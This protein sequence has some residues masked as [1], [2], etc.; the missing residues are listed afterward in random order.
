MQT[1]YQLLKQRFNSFEELEKKISELPDSYDRGYAFEDFAQSFFVLQKARYQ[2]KDF[3]L[4]KDIPVKIAELL[5]LEEKD[6]GVDGIIVRID[7]AIIAVQIKFRSQNIPLTYT[8]LSTFWTEA[9]HADGCLTFTNSLN[10]PK[11]A[12][13]RRIP[14]QSITL[15]ELLDLDTAFFDQMNDYFNGNTISKRKSYNREDHQIKIIEET[16]EKIKTYDRG[17]IIAACGTGKTVISKWLHDDLNSKAT[18]FFAPSLALIKQTIDSWTTNTD[19]PFMYMAVCSDQTV[20]N[21]DENDAIDYRAH[22]MSF[23]VSTSPDDIANFL[24]SNTDFPKVIFCTYQSADAIANALQT[25]ET[26]SK[27]K[28]SLGLY[29]EAHRTAG[30]KNSSMFTVALEDESIPV[31]KRIFLTATE[32]VASPRLKRAYEEVGETIYSMD[33]IEQYGHT[34]STYN[35]GQAIKDKII[36]NYQMVVCSISEDDIADL[37]KSYRNTV[38]IDTS[39]EEH[40][41]TVE[42]LLLQVILAKAFDEL[43]IHKTVAYLNRVS[44]AKRFINNPTNDILLSD[45]FSQVATNIPE[46]DLYTNAVDGSMSAK[47]RKKILD[48]FANAPFGVIANAK[49]LTEG[50]DVPAIDAVFFA[51]PKTSTVDIIQAIGRA[52]R[53]PKTEDKTAYIILPVIVPPGVQTFDGINAEAFET[54][55]NVI[56]ALADQDSDLKDIIEQINYSNGR[57]GNFGSNQKPNLPIQYLPIGKLN[58]PN[59][60]E[61][62]QFRIGDVNSRTTEDKILLKALT[63]GSRGSNI[64]RSFTSISDYKEEAMFT[65]LIKP[66]LQIFKDRNVTI[67]SSNEIKINNNNVSHTYRLGAIEKLP[68]RQY[69]LTDIGYKIMNNEVSN[70]DIF[71]VQMLRYYIIDKETGGIIFPYRAW[72]KVLLEVPKIRKLDFIYALYTLHDTTEESIVSAVDAVKYLQETY[73]YESQLSVKNKTDVLKLLNQRFNTTL[74]FNDV[75][76]SRGTSYNQFNYFIKHLL[77]FDKFIFFDKSNS[78]VEI[79]QGERAA[80]RELLSHHEYLEKLAGEGNITKL[81]EEYTKIK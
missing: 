44:T 39:G 49:C 55:H 77:S 24:T 59:F 27:F 15:N 11:E 76:T 10:I 25:N 64:S 47:A 7:G 22:E 36:A 28:F 81:R 1:K 34:F 46:H 56:S 63:S 2:I 68:K 51:N 48:E 37:L 61:S 73:P 50:V 30:G 14:Q 32:R 16:L 8:E 17:K 79:M 13:N 58:I 45:I 66:T 9:D 20:V 54:I 3:Y 5:K 21:N 40:E 80:V 75:W 26:L 19:Q 57:G 33:N 4:R 60:K 18:I 12:A 72:L 70:N 67:L 62:L 42:Q 65:S 38:N 31:N 35:F 78:T 6:H 29:D 43:P 74:G 53:K 41:I 52:L 69:T 71:K 23:P